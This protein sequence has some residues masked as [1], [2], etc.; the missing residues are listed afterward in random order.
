[1]AGYCTIRGDVLDY[2]R[3]VESLGDSAYRLF[4]LTLYSRGR[5]ML[6][7]MRW[8]PADAL[9][10]VAGWGLPEVETALAELIEADLLAYDAQARLLLNPFTLEFA[11]VKGINQVRGALALLRDLPDSPVLLPALGHV[12]AAARSL[13]RGKG[14]P[15]DLPELVAELEERQA[16]LS[17]TPLPGVAGVE[18][19]AQYPSE[20]GSG[21]SAKP[22]YPC[23]GVP[24]GY[25]RGSDTPSIPPGR[26]SDTPPIP[27]GR[28]LDTPRIP[29]TRTR[30]R[31]D[32]DPDPVRSYDSRED[33]PH[34]PPP[35][36]A[37][38]EVWQGG[39]GAG[40][41]GQARTAGK[42]G[43]GREPPARQDRQGQGGGAPR[44]ERLGRNGSKYAG[45]DPRKRG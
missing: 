16:A 1:M 38:G 14:Q 2:D 12:L 13:A 3:R 35:R 31:S 8:V 20:G 28:G 7:V 44:Q 33:P 39:S 17:G 6:G 9:P 37:A 10:R 45:L 42:G 24:D 34:S 19:G 5:T 30:A 18:A 27:L 43:G 41:Q 26:G 22:E 11:P 21:Q 23:Q 32:P 40:A 25:G 29:P 4:M 15:A 36:R